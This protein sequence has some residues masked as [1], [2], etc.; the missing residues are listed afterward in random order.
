MSNVIVFPSVATA[1]AS[2]QLQALLEAHERNR[3]SRSPEED[4]ANAD[5]DALFD[6]L[7]VE[8]FDANAAYDHAAYEAETA[9]ARKLAALLALGIIA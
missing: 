1:S 8:A 5:R 7:I 2:D 4:V 3:A 6:R 9:A